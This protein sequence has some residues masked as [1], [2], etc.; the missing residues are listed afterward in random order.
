MNEYHTTYG[1]GF[2]RD[3][4]LYCSRLNIGAAE[5]TRCLFHTGDFEQFVSEFEDLIEIEDEK[6]DNGTPR[7]YFYF[8]SQEDSSHNF[9]VKLMRELASRSDGWI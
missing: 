7:D 6:A 8:I 2:N 3:K 4:A 5:V 9:A 1:N